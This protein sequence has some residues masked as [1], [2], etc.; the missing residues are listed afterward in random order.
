MLGTAAQPADLVLVLDRSGSM[1][2]S[3]NALEDN[4]ISRL[5]VASAGARMLIARF[6]PADDARVAIVAYDDDAAELTTGFTN[7]SDS[8]ALDDIVQQGYFDA[9]AAGSTSM[10]AGVEEAL[11]L[12]STEDPRRRRQSIFLLTD[13]R[14]NTAPCLGIDQSPDAADTGACSPAGPEEVILD[15]ETVFD[16]VRVCSIGMGREVG[17]VDENVLES[18]SNQYLNATSNVASVGPS[19]GAFAKC[20]PTFTEDGIAVDP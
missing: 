4:P 19:L 8:T 18:F 14:Q 3:D 9:G 12:L 6:D 20:A 17:Q 13:G 16:Q 1:N 7:V 2:T 15:S 10:G 11:A 5:G